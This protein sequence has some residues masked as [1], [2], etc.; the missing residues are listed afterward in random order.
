VEPSDTEIKRD[1]Y[2]RVRQ[3]VD[4]SEDDEDF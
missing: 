2:R 4:L 1:K 3:S